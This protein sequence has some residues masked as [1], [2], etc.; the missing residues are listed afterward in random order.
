MATKFTQFTRGVFPGQERSLPFHEATQ[1]FVVVS[2]SN[3]GAMV[4]S[5]RM[6]GLKYGPAAWCL[7]PYDDV[8]E[9]ILNGQCPRVGDKCVVVFAGVGVTDPV[10]LAWWR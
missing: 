6:A 4:E 1:I 7:G 9:A 10:I 8:D 5:S 2:V 3:K